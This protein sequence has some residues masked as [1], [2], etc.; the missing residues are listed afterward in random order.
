MFAVASQ[1]EGEEEEEEDRLTAGK[2]LIPS[3]LAAIRF[4]KSEMLGSEEGSARTEL[5]KS[6]IRT[7]PTGAMPEGYTRNCFK[8]NFGETCQRRGGEHN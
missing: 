4:T 3:Q 2:A 5:T 8:G 7:L 6:F 1:E